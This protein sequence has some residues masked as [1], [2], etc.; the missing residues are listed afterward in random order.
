MYFFHSHVSDELIIES[1]LVHPP[2]ESK[3]IGMLDLTFV[4]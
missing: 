1:G 4:L 3:K 2:G